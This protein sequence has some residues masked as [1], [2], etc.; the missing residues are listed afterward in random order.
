MTNILVTVPLPPVMPDPSLDIR[1]ATA[2]DVD[3]LARL[4]RRAYGELEDMGFPSSMTTATPDRFVDWL[5]SRE[6]FVAV[7]DT[8]LTGAVHLI[9]REEWPCPELGRLAVD[10]AHHGRGIGGRLR[11]HV[12][13]V[14]RDR[15][16]DRIR[17]RTFTGHPFLRDWYEQA[18]YEH[19]ADQALDTPH[20]DLHV[21]EKELEPAPGG[22]SSTSETTD[23]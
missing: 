12:E 1:P 17:L 7:V 2:A 8:E 6:I 15:G 13:A 21:L 19:V 18:G 4:Y 20:Y 16:H 11:E 10:P 14:A 3:A 9:P 5:D 22:H 23:T